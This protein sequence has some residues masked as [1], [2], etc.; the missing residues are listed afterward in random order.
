MNSVLVF[1]DIMLDKYIDGS[2][3]RISPE[4]P[5]PIV[6]VN[7]E[8]NAIGGC[9][10][11]SNGIAA[12]EV[13][14]EIISFVGEDEH[15][16]TLIALL[17]KTSIK[18]HIITHQ[19]PTITKV[20]VVSNKHQ[21]L[22]YDIEKIDAP[23]IKIQ[24]QV[25]KLIEK[26][27][28]K[29]AI[30]SDY[31]K[32]ACNINLCACIINTFNKNNRKVLVDPKS[33]DWTKYK[34]AFLISPNFKEFCEAIGKNIINENKEI[35]V[36]AKK[37]IHLYNIENI[38]VTRSSKGMSLISSTNCLHIPTIANEVFDVTGAGDTVI[39]TI[40]AMLCKGKSLKESV[41]LANKAAA[42]AIAHF[43]TYAVS[44]KELFKK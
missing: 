37:L 20:R 26:S 2:V 36:A 30:I 3:T 27:T 34:G 28:A 44:K 8:Y 43:G 33:S 5:V 6:N 21:L 23:V 38:L 39:A 11:V 15:A 10:N 7:N 1:G 31:G 12:L 17:K 32:G 42:I 40:G 18:L 19:L 29:V 4:A 9:G 16:K 14:N 25:I 35:E 24:H 22:R 41:L 13:D